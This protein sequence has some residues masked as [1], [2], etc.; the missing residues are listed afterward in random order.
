MKAVIPCAKK[1]EALFPLS[2]TKPT[3]LMK[4]AGE[5]IVKRLIDVLTANGIEEVL[6]VTN[7]REE[8]F[9]DE[10]EDTEDV[11]LVHQEQLGGT[12]SAVAACSFIEED[13]IVVNG[14]VVVSEKDVES[15]I[16][17]FD[18]VGKTC[19][20]STYQ[21]RPEKFGVLSIENDRVKSLEEKPEDP[22][23]PLINTGIYAFTPEIFEKIEVLQADEKN[24][25]DA[26]QKMIDDK[27]ANFVLAEDYWI[28]IGSCRKLW[29][30]DRVKRESEISE[31]D[32]HEE[33]KVE[34]K[35]NGK[36]RVKKGAIVEQGAQ[37]K[38]KCII[39]EETVVEAGTVVKGSTI[40]E[41]CQLDQCSVENSLTFENS[42]LD[43]FIAIE[44]SVL[45]E[46]SD[47]KPGSVI[48]E[49]FIG[50]E[51]F[52]EGNNT[53]LGTKFVPGAR[54]DIGEISK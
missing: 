10:F 38:G 7:Y 41:R 31:T 2:E 22:E 29:E 42:I 30:A 40:G 13:F 3:G 12:A 25:T 14:D 33:A 15:L 26:V 21:N 17:K 5:P 36:A 11:R 16:Q 8:E 53:I 28:D 52:I 45:G 35:I 9:E 19:I 4:V 32:I 51:S 47:I 46:K 54:T 34:G 27:G 44:D 43:S 39:G 49:S 6:L 23:N 1:K 24:L 20:L 18:E 37:L 48:R 50:A